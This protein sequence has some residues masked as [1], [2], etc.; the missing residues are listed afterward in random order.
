MW[1]D[2]YTEKFGEKLS[3]SCP[4]RLEVAYLQTVSMLLQNTEKNQVRIIE[5][6]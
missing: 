1:L 4:E 5:A 2:I 6:L 3:F